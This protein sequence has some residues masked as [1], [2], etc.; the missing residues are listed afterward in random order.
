MKNQLRKE[1]CFNNIWRRTSLGCNW[2]DYDERRL[3][4]DEFDSSWFAHTLASAPNDLNDFDLYVGFVETYFTRFI[5]EWIVHYYLNCIYYAAYNANKFYDGRVNQLSHVRPSGLYTSTV[6]E[7]RIESIDFECNLSISISYQQ[8]I[9]ICDRE[10]KHSPRIKIRLICW[11][12]L[13]RGEELMTFFF[14]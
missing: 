5:A 14:C 12:I 10:T 13:S 8:P 7:S 11:F 1:Y 4:M 9:S 3:M 6:F 2:C